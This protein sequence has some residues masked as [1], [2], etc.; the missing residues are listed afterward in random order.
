MDDILRI[1]GA[2]TAELEATAVAKGWANLTEL[3]FERAMWNATGA[4]STTLPLKSIRSVVSVNVLLPDRTA[5]ALLW[6]DDALDLNPAHT[7]LGVALAEGAIDRAFLVGAASL[8][9]WNRESHNWPAS[10]G[11]I[12]V[13]LDGE[14]FRIRTATVEALDDDILDE[15]PLRI[16]RLPV[17]LLAYDDEG[18][19]IRLFA[20]APAE[21]IAELVVSESDDIVAITLFERALVG[22]YPDGAL[23]ASAAVARF[24]CLELEL[25]LGGRK[26]IDGSTGTDLPLRDRNAPEAEHDWH[27][28]RVLRRGCPRWIP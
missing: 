2:C 28:A 26:L 15:G 13:M 11:A 6:G 5:I 24:G 10:E 17:E 1:V 21:S 19:T 18:A 22:F 4:R 27:L 14:P 20:E 7:L 23:N 16:E 9:T 8:S 12:P 3:D 25:R